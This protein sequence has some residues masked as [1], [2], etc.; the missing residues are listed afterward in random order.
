MNKQKQKLENN[1]ELHKISKN[2]SVEGKKCCERQYTQP[3]LPGCNL[4]VRDTY[5]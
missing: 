1:T 4:A 2:G 5:F 3:V